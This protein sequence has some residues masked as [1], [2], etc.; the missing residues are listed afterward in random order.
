MVHSYFDAKLT[1]PDLDSSNSSDCENSD[2]RLDNIIS[3]LLANLSVYKS[4][5]EDDMTIKKYKKERGKHERSSEIDRNDKTRHTH[6]NHFNFGATAS[7]SNPHFP[8]TRRQPPVENHLPFNSDL[9]LYNYDTQPSLPKRPRS[10]FTGD[11]INPQKLNSDRRSKVT[12]IFNENSGNN[13][14]DEYYMATG[15]RSQVPF[16]VEESQMSTLLKEKKGWKIIAVGADGACL[17]RAVAHQIFGDEEKHMIIREQVINYMKQNR[18]H[19]SQFISE[20][21]EHYLIRKLDP[22]THGNHVEIQAI[23]ELYNRPVEI[24]HNSLEP[25]NV[26]HREYNDL[27]PLRLSYHGGIHYNSIVDPQNPTFGE[28]LGMPNYQPRL[29]EPELVE[30]AKNESENIQIE[31]TMLQNR[32]LQ[33]EN[34]AIE[35]SIAE[36]VA[37]ESYLEYLQF[38]SSKN[39]KSDENSVILK[40]SFKEKHKRPLSPSSSS[41]SCS[42]SGGDIKDHARVIQSVDDSILRHM[43]VEMLDM[44][45]DDVLAM[46][47]ENSRQEY[48]ASYSKERTFEPSF[49]EDQ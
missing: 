40:K 27:P 16:Q 28:G 38:L 17:F 24:Y 9:R 35:R 30:K 42:Y 45:E 7:D 2:D 37:K 26:F 25:I 44:D 18:E 46:V 10:L 15:S 19:F 48:L 41:A 1:Q 22:H 21:F 32:I 4:E 29:S 5:N 34:Q 12:D 43:P 3:S 33:S 23:S 8:V 11:C 47:L 6:N 20:D 49:G 13:S 31:E 39:K 14:E 36:Q